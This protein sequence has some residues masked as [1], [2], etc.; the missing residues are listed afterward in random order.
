MSEPMLRAPAEA[1]VLGIPAPVLHGILLVATVTCFCWILHRRLVLLRRAAPD[2]SHQ[3]AVELAQRLA[4][5]NPLYALEVFRAAIGSTEWAAEASRWDPLT[6]ARL[7]KV[8][9]IRLKGLSQR[10][11]SLLESTAVLERHATPGSVAT[12]AG[13]T[14]AEAADISGD[15]YNRGLLQDRAN[16]LGRGASAR[17]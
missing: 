15:L 4:G 11:I 3:P 6:D 13:L 8:L 12:V 1:G 9:A 10:A 16:R 7:S 2:P 17:W 5:G 14:L